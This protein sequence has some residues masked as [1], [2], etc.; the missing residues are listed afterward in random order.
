V[1]S[2]VLAA[3]IMSEAEMTPPISALAVVSSRHQRR[4]ARTAAWNQ[5]MV[6]GYEDG[7]VTV[8]VHT[9]G[10]TPGSGLTRG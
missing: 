9:G 7:L 6:Q 8:S 10:L 4:D 5:D 3:V 2:R 1:A